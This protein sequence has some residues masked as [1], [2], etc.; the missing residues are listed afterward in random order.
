MIDSLRRFV[1]RSPTV[2]LVLRMGAAL[3]CFVIAAALSVLPGPAFVFWIAGLVLLGFSAGQILLS[4]HAVQD[5]LRRH[6]PW[7]DR[8]PRLSQR[9]IRRTL[10]HP[11]VKSIDRFSGREAQRRSK[12]ERRGNR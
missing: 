2:R 8:L 9:Q 10:R 6:V 7:F 11:W 12:R 5:F 4:V 3:V 1:P